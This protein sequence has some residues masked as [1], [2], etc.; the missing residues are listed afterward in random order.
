M[1]A[2]AAPGPD[3]DLPAAYV[4]EPPPDGMVLTEP[5]SSPPSQLPSVQPAKPSLS[6]L[7]R[8]STTTS[9]S[10]RLKASTAKNIIHDASSPS[11][12]LTTNTTTHSSQSSS[13]P[14]SSI[15]HGAKSNSAIARSRAA[16]RS[17]T[18]SSDESKEGGGREGSGL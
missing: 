2:G 7:S 13:A 17:P 18:K 12:A 1:S 11:S 4:A 6:S 15:L 5:P 16:G 10:T 14:S 3:E 9:R 8:P